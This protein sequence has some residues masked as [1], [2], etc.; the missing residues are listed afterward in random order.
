[1]ATAPGTTRPKP[2]GFYIAVTC[3]GCGSSL[4]LD[5]DFF[6]VKCEHC[7]SVHRVIT[8]D[9]PAAYLVQNRVDRREGQ[10]VVDR[11]LKSHGRRLTGRDLH[12]KQVYYP[13]W[14]I[15][16][17]L[18]RLRNKTYERSIASDDEGGEDL[19]YEQNSTEISLSPYLTVL[20]AG[21]HVAGI[22]DSLGQRT[23]YVQLVPFSRENI[24]EEYEALPL[25]QTW[26]NLRSQLTVNI[27]RIAGLDAADFGTNRT[28]L[29]HPR[30]SV[31]YFPF[32]VFET[33]D[34]GDFNRYVID[35]LTGRFLAHVDDVANE[36][37]E[38]EVG[39]VD[40][41]FGALTVEHHR[42]ATCGVD[43]PAVQSWAYIC[44]NC[45]ELTI[46]GRSGYKPAEIRLAG[47]SGLTGQDVLVPFWLFR[48]PEREAADIR[49]MFS[50]IHGSD[51]L[52]IPAFRVGNFNAMY[53][54]TRRA[55]AAMATI[56]SEPVE[57]FD[58]RLR[59]VEISGDEAL[60]LAE[61]MIFRHRSEHRSSR[62]ERSGTLRPVDVRLLYLP[63]HPQQYFMVDSILNAVTFEKSL[64]R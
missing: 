11:Y 31:V 59:P 35:G 64:L 55:T 46:L 15:E 22:P 10:F 38:D 6:V 3:P 45:R 51:W 62:Q 37:V 26:E 23:D 30:A 1:M 27:S 44:R 25:V 2:N 13:Y 16:A 7:R 14:R 61:V 12:L 29:F 50:G 53:R 34:G 36:V 48:L 21:N 19:T 58:A 9:S 4:A 49:A 18:Y 33:Y 63:F 24:P 43:L 32:L 57:S 40:I 20:R 60:A 54:L 56:G 17:I 8:P 5:D 41:E 42:C 52:T 39:P 28:E 47:M